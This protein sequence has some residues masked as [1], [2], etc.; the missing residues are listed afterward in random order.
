MGKARRDLR[1]DMANLRKSAILV[2][3]RTLAPDLEAILQDQVN[4]VIDSALGAYRRLY[5][6]P[7]KGAKTEIDF[8]VYGDIWASAIEDEIGA[9]RMLIPQR[10]SPAIDSIVDGVSEKASKM[11]GSEEVPPVRNRRRRSAGLVTQVTRINE[12]T[13]NRLRTIIH[14]SIQEGETIIEAAETVRNKLPSLSTNR[15][16]TIV[17]TEMGRAADEAVKEA[18]VHSEIVTH[19]SVVGCE[20]VEPNIPTLD[21]DPTCNIRGV[22]IERERELEFHINHTGAIV[23]SA[24]R[25]QDGSVPVVVQ[26]GGA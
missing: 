26:R 1:R 13:K 5:G 15:V 22:P 19:I 24:F 23:A 20:A 9:T 2:A 6:A 16:P 4:R 21:G 10:L 3:M 18:M 17:R 25:K 11:L 8:A 12:A 14:R 7:L